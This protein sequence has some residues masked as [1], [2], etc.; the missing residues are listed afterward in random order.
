MYI[1]FSTIC[2]VR[3]QLCLKMHL[4]LVRGD[5]CGSVYTSARN[6]GSVSSERLLLGETGAG[7]YGPLVT[8]S[9]SMDRYITLFSVCFYIRTPYL[10]SIIDSLTLNSGL[11]K[12]YLTRAFSRRHIPALLCS[13]AYTARQH[14][15]RG[16]CKQRDRQQEAQNRAKRDTKRAMTRTL[17][18][19][20]RDETRSSAWPCWPQLGRCAMDVLL[21]AYP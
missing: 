19:V 6:P 16:H 4:L 1:G 21:R 10:I 7:C 11:S 2:G 18:Y 13:G 12:P 8:T 3:H 15:T 20:G 14:Y 9:S 17:V 5:C